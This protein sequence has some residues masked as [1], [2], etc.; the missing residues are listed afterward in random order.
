MLVLLWQSWE[1]HLTLELAVR[2]KQPCILIE[3]EHSVQKKH[4]LWEHK[5]GVYSFRKKN[6]VA[7]CR[8][9]GQAWRKIRS[10]NLC[11]FLF[12]GMLLDQIPSLPGR[13]GMARRVTASAMWR[14][15][16]LILPHKNHSVHS[17]FPASYN[18]NDPQGDFERQPHAKDDVSLHLCMIVNKRTTLPTFHL[19]QCCYVSKKQTSTWSEPRLSTE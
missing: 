16:I 2:R 8:E 15:E 3:E 18:D 10:W 13:V 11:F 1:W 9:P 12:Q 19:P 6:T 17:S 5:L 4:S 14:E 7:G